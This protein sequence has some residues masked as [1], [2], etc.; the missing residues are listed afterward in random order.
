MIVF[1][2][3]WA[4]VCVCVCARARACVCVVNMFEKKRKKKNKIGELW[5]INVSRIDLFGQLFAVVI[6]LLWSNDNV[7]FYCKD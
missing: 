6:I 2:C 3:V 7:L 4:C 5:K 1:V